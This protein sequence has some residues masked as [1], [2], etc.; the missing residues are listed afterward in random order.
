MIHLYTAATGNGQRPA[1]VLE[2]LGLAYRV[3]KVDLA[4]GDQRDPEFLRL[5]PRGQIPVIVDD[6]GPGGQRLV[7]TQSHAILLHYAMQSGKLLPEAPL[8]RAQALQWF[9]FAA[10][11][12]APTSGAV[13]AL[14]HFVPEKVESTTQFFLD[15][16]IAHFRYADERLGQVAYLAGPLSIADLALY[17]VYAARMREIEAQGGLAN[18][19][20]WG[21]ALAGRPSVQK[22]M[23]VPG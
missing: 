7:L 4:K 6:E 12:A 13:F 3:H 16:L 10:S 9:S 11:D 15:R 19:K 20:R 21:E 22:A 17:P 23:Q 5:N 1:L 18:L 8:E 2:E 14:G